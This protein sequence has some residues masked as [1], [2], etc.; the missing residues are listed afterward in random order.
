MAHRTEPA[1]ED[2][3]RKPKKPTSQQRVTEGS[4]LL[5]KPK[6]GGWGW[7]GVGEEWEPL[8]RAALASLRNFLVTFCDDKTSILSRCLG[9]LQCDNFAHT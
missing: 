8:M 2:K 4:I 3:L 7:G 6:S 5:L 1:T 9:I